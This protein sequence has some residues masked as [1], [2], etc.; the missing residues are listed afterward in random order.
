MTI[1]EGDRQHSILLG[2][3]AKNPG[4]PSLRD[5]FSRNNGQAHWLYELPGMAA[6]PDS[7]KKT[8]GF[9]TIRIPQKYRGIGISTNRHGPPH[10]IT[11]IQAG[12]ATACNC[13]T[14]VGE[15]I[16]HIDLLPTNTINHAELPRALQLGSS[17]ETAQRQETC[18]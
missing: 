1:L 2:W 7:N 8:E 14:L 3:Q 5:C 9:R 15:L 17:T 12:S 13:N 16:T 10:T 6:D 4:S 18:T 11:S